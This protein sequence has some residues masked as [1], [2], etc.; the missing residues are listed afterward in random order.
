MKSGIEIRET[1]QAQ[2]AGQK[3]DASDEQQVAVKYSLSTHGRLLVRPVTPDKSHR[4]HCGEQSE[5]QSHIAKGG[6]AAG[7]RQQQKYGDRGGAEEL[8]RQ[9][10]VG[11]VGP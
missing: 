9:H 7:L 6:S 1:Q 11:I 4:R 8:R 3:K 10:T 5:H 2:S